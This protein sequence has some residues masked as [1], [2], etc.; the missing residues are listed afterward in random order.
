[1][2]SPARE[3]A[4]PGLRH[5]AVSGAALFLAM[6][7]TVAAVGQTA[8]DDLERELV[9][10][11]TLSVAIDTCSDLD[12]PTADETKLD[13]AISAVEAKLALTEE[14]SEALYAR[15]S[16]TADNDKDGFCKEVAS[17]FKEAIAK[18]PD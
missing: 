9:G 7:A 11:Y 18:L 2:P 13:Q 1:V 16:A 8:V 6:F 3:C 17:T 14:A 10:L 5:A 4:L 15:L 12:V